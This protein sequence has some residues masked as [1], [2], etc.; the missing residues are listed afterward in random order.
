MELTVNQ[1]K[2]TVDSNLSVG[3]LIVQLLGDHT[4]G[5]AVAVGQE[6]IP[7]SSWNEVL[8]KGNESVTLITATQGG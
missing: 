4:R 3:Q 6:I 7:R 5:V 8:L 1:K 2:I